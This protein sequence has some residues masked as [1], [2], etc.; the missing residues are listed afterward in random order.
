MREGRQDRPHLCGVVAAVSVHKNEHIERSGGGDACRAGIAIAAPLFAHHLGAGG[1]GHLC[2]VVG[3]SVVHDDDRVDLV[4][5]QAGDH[6][7]DR[8]LFVQGGDDDG[9]FHDSSPLNRAAWRMAITLMLSMMS[10]ST[11]MRRASA[12]EKSLTSINSV[13]SGG[14]G[15]GDRASPT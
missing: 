7:C 14:R 10:Q 1:P 12:N 13:S 4:A 9:D 5:R 2:C 3:G 8:I 15:A 11:T 6:V